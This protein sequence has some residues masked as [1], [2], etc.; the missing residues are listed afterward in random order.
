[1]SA[2][3]EFIRIQNFINGQFKDAE[4]GEWLDNHE[5]ATG[6]VYSSVASSDAADVE[7][8][9]QAA[10]AAFPGWKKTP[11]EQRSKYL[12]R[13]AEVLT[14]RLVRESAFQLLLLR[15]NSHHWSPQTTDT[16]LACH[17]MNLPLLS[18]RTTASQ[19]R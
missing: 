4:S 1:M 11:A 7:T 5:P 15:F 2:T 6:K 19:S 17:R 8:A 10:K 14:S 9:Y 16:I 18:L 13:I 12:N 3:S